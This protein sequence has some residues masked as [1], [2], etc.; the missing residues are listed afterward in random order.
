MRVLNQT[1]SMYF[2]LPTCLWLHLSCFVMV[3]F[4]HIIMCV[5]MS[6]FEKVSLTKLK[7]LMCL[8]SVLSHY[9][10]QM[11]GKIE[12]NQHSEQYSLLIF[13]RH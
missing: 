4:S 12:N 8:F 6:I 5:E 3:F 10:F 9:K 2:W 7:H 11:R 13:R 1:G